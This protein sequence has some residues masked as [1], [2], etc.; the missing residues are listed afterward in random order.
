MPI[1]PH[2]FLHAPAITQEPDIDSATK[3]ARRRRLFLPLLFLGLIALTATQCARAP[4]GDYAD[5]KHFA[6]GQFR[7]LKWLVM[8]VTLAIYYGLPWLRWYRGPDLPNQAVLLDM[9]NNRYFFFIFVK[10]CFHFS[11]I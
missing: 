9:P 4:L 3:P 6:D 1:H 8:G 7:K 10:T 2:V 5:S 11:L